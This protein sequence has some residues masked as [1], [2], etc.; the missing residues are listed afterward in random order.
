MTS[1][2]PVSRRL[3]LL[4]LAALMVGV[5]LPAVADEEPP[6]LPLGDE[7]LPETRETVVVAD[8]VTLT[9]IVRGSKPARQRQIA[10]TSRGPWRVSV[11]ELDPAVAA[12]ALRATYGPDLA[13]T[14]P[15][16]E[17][18]LLSDAQSAV[19]AS[20]F[21]LNDS[22]T[23]PGDPVGTAVYDGEVMSEPT[24]A[25]SEVAVM[26][27]SRTNTITMDRLTWAGEVTNQLTGAV[28]AI[29]HLNH[30]PA[31]P[32]PCAGSKRP[33]R[34]TEP[35]R[36]VALSPR[37]SARTPSGSGVEVVLDRNGC[38]LRREKWRGVR[39][40]PRQSALQATGAES[41]ALW[42]LARQGCLERH[43]ALVRSNGAPVEVGPW[44]QVV[45]GRFRLTL[46]GRVVAPTGRDPFFARHPRTLVGRTPGGTIKLVTI[47]GRR[48]TSVGATLREAAEVALALGMTNAVNLD[49]G[50]STTMVVG[51]ALQNTPSGDTERA[52]GDA[53]VFV[54]S[55]V[56]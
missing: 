40:G 46:R 33:T 49:G 15:V 5:S 17:L 8:G 22:K 7:D 24:P 10:T 26:V 27:D 9:R 38:V 42:R 53:L 20:F 19:N 28:L 32:E 11:L 25:R 41:L 18:A 54:P 1:G 16:S 31:V 50:G 48:G 55:A 3:L 12:G 43:V 4:V 39:L 13:R 44:L 45:N 23:Y 52:V 30:P 35:G 14:E 47:D 34:C 37:F 29:Q 6:P 51:G 2:G 36:V 21:S 56:D